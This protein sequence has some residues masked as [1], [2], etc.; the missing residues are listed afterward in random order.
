MKTG[1][2][3]LQTMSNDVKLISVGFLEAN[4]PILSLQSQYRTWAQ[5]WQVI[6][7][8]C[9][10]WSVITDL[11]EKVTRP[12]NLDTGCTEKLKIIRSIEQKEYDQKNNAALAAILAGVSTDLQYIVAGY[13]GQ[14]ESARLA[15][16]ALK[17][18]FGHETLQSILENFYSLLQL[19]MNE[20]DV[21]SD[22][23]SNFEAAYAHL[24]NQCSESGMEEAKHLKNFLAS[25]SVKTMLLL[26][27]LPRSFEKI[28]DNLVCKE[29]LSYASVN[30]RLL[31]IQGS[32]F[33]S[34]RGHR[35]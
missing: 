10:Y 22:H 24:F 26:R 17:N 5:I 25:D 9:D 28:V 15:W 19:E 35:A 2:G 33:S 14:P 31:K 30:K 23:V 11:D 4:L 3:T 20:G 21:I 7:M 16:Q 13:V 18:K 29:H 34:L 27:S 6:L 1:L 32:Q 12:S 8:G